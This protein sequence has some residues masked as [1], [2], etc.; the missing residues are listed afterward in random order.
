MSKNK[1]KPKKKLRPKFLTYVQ[2]SRE[3]ENIGHTCLPFDDQSG[4]DTT[5]NGE[6]IG[7]RLRATAALEDIARVLRQIRDGQA[8]MTSR[9]SALV[10][11]S[12]K[13]MAR[14]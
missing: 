8:T 2:Q 4:H 7:T 6:E 10:A 12:K 3:T 9:I 14:R 11:Q 5:G 1:P 13:A